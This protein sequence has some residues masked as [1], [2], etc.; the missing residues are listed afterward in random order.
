MWSLLL[1]VAFGSLSRID[2]LAQASESSAS[3]AKDTI[4][5]DVAII[6]GGSAGTH[7]AVSLKDKGKS[8][9]L[10]EAKGRLGGHTEVSDSLAH[11]IRAHY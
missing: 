6:G 9:I 3:S 11:Y 2:G 7:A 4:V 5:R 10:I 8:V 1:I